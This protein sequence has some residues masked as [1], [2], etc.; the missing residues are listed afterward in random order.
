MIRFLSQEQD[1]PVVVITQCLYDGTFLNVYDVGVKA[2][3]AG[4]VSGHDMTTEA[5][6]TKLM[7]ILGKTRDS[8][9]VRGE[10]QTNYCDE[11]TIKAV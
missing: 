8:A 9:R 2:A 7:W 5:A 3:R 4:A 10:I 11:I 1:I 6:V